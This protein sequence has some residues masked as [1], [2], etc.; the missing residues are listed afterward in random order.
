MVK[1]RVHSV[2]ERTDGRLSAFDLFIITLICLNVVV[3]I[4]ET[5]E[6]I[7]QVAPLAFRTF[8]TVSVAIFTVEYVL[9]IWSC[10]SE[11]KYGHPLWGRLRFAVTPVLFIDLLAILPFYVALIAPAGLIDLR[12]LRILRAVRL[13]A[14]IAR[15]SRYSS[16]L[17]TSAGVLHAKRAELITVIVFL[18]ILLLMASSLM[19]FAEH[20]AQ[21]DK[22]AN[23]PQAMWWSIITLT[24]VGYGDVTPVTGAGRFFAGVIAILGIGLFALPAGILGSGFMEEMNR[25][26]QETR[27]CPHCN[28]EIHE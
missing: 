10:T 27:R 8:N 9:R 3:L 5:V 25:R 7:H 2:L 17:R 26:R 23:I 28:M 13:L 18:S 1:S 11:E 4:V 12:V 15:L 22:F 6:E 16:G 19:F 20:E 21:P 24:T 14:R